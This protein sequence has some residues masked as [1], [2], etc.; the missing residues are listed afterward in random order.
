AVGKRLVTAAQ[1]TGGTIQS[2]R[3]APL[4]NGV[5]SGDGI[6]AFLNDVTLAA[7]GRTAF[8]TSSQ[9]LLAPT[10]L[11]LDTQGNG[12]EAA[13]TC[14]GK[15]CKSAV[16]GGVFASPWVNNRVDPTRMAL[17]GTHVF[18]T[19]DTLTGAQ[20]PSAN[21]VDLTLT[22]LGIVGSGPFQ[23]VTKI[24]YGTRDNPNMLV[25]GAGTGLWQSTTATAGSLLQVTTYEGQTPTGIVLDPRSQLR[26]FVADYFRL[27]GT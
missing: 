8:Y 3:N 4:W 22:D 2:A 5:Q 17:G 20:G 19:Q 18:V 1:D 7:S 24:A 25:A 6:N 10:R 15:D 26:Y 16:T 21:T 11:I 9:F 27:F 14:N 23:A 12:F 13:V